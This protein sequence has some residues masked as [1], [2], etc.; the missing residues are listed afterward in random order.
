MHWGLGRM[1]MVRRRQIFFNVCDIKHTLFKTKKKLPR[2]FF[3]PILHLVKICTN[4][5]TRKVPVSSQETYSKVRFFVLKVIFQLTHWPVSHHDVIKE[6]SLFKNEQKKV[7][8][9]VSLVL[10]T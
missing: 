2:K 4:C 3:Q 1:K 6:L 8:L 10:E 5:I 7:H 9:F